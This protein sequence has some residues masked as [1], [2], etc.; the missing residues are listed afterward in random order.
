MLARGEKVGAPQQVQ[1]GLR[2]IA[3]HLVADFFDSHH[4]KKQVFEL[5][6]LDLEKPSAYHC[7]LRPKIKDQR[8]S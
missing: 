2:M 6:S 7:R 1:V 5:W 4:K 3:P 8:P